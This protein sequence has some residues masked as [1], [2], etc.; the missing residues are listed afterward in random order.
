MVRMFLSKRRKT[1]KTLKLNYKFNDNKSMKHITIF[2]FT[3]NN[4]KKIKIKTKKFNAFRI[5]HM[6][7]IEKWIQNNS[8]F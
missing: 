4:N 7:S 1:N 8:R 5:L 6:I 2:K 3:N